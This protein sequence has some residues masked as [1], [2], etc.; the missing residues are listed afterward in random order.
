MKKLFLLTISI[1]FVLAGCTESQTEPDMQQTPPMLTGIFAPE[2]MDFPEEY[3]CLPDFDTEYDP[4][5]QTVTFAGITFTEVPGESGMSGYQF[6]HSLFT[7]DMEGFQTD[8]FDFPLPHNV[9]ITQG[10]LTEEDIWFFS[11][12]YEET[13]SV[14]FNRMDRETKELLFQKDV[15]DIR[16]IGRNITPQDFCADAEGDLY[17]LLDKQILIFNKK[18]EVIGQIK[19]KNNVVSLTCLRNGSVYAGTV[20]NGEQGIARVDKEKEILDEMFPLGSYDIVGTASHDL[21][22]RNTIGVYAV[23]F[24]VDGQPVTECLIDH[25]NSG[26]LSTE[27]RFIAMLDETSALYVRSEYD[28]ENMLHQTPVLYRKVPDRDVADLTVLELAYAHELETPFLEEIIRFNGMHPDIRISLMNY[29][30][31]EEEEAGVRRLLTDLQTG[32]IRPDILYDTIGDGFGSPEH[33]VLRV[34]AE[35]GQFYDLNR[36]LETDQIVSKNNVFGAVQRAF[37]TEQGQMWGISPYF[38]LYTY[39]PTVDLPEEIRERGHWT[40]EEFLDFAEQLPGG[41]YLSQN[42]T[43]ETLG[44][45]VYTDYGDFIDRQ[46][47]TC[48]F[49]SDLFRRYLEYL[50]SLPTE[51][52][53][54]AIPEIGDADFNKLDELYRNQVFALRLTAT[55]GIDILYH[56]DAYRLTENF[57]L[58]GSPNQTEYGAKFQTDFGFM[59]TSFAE[60]PEESWELIRMFMQIPSDSEVWSESVGISS[61]ISFFEREADQLQNHTAV[62]YY[63]DYTFASYPGI[64]DLSEIPGKVY[65]S[66]DRRGIPYRIVPVSDE[67]VQYLSDYLNREGQPLLSQLPDTVNDIIKEEISV[68]LGGVGTAADCAGKIQSRVEIWLAEH[69]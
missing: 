63:D 21:C 34:M 31:P 47:N 41:S 58:I 68:F 60:H 22:Y 1:L 64:S 42:C 15:S 43:Q 23:D 66:F 61:L 5:T 59:I 8:R 30:D 9:K 38:S 27:T 32:T 24:S 19:L 62:A 10:L 65:T 26:I 69:Q 13:A 20:S 29:T 44:F 18:L 67:R 2:P 46:N 39:L 4:E 7:Y 48:S 6:S 49:D 52:E 51:K 50:K 16:E 11:I 25:M 3:S 33:S 57:R 28:E 53:Y 40:L 37:R 17:L 36:F 35:Q 55:S 12:V 45:N 54:R 56:S 14:Y